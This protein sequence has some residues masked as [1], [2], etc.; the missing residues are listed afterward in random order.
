MQPLVPKLVTSELEDIIFMGKSISETVNDR[1][2]LLVHYPSGRGC[3]H[4]RASFVLV[5]PITQ[6]LAVQGTEQSI[7]FR[8]RL[9]NPLPVW[10]SQHSP[11]STLDDR[12]PLKVLH[13]E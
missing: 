2:L 6:S 13:L 3:R 9:A 11:S 12:L 10:N 4:E 7:D 5:F 1:F 8:V